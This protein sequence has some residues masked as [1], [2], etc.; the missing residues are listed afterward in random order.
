MATPRGSGAAPPPA[1][2]PPAVERILAATRPRLGAGV[3]AVALRDLG[4]LGTELDRYVG[5]RRERIER[6]RGIIEE[7]AREA[8][9]R[10]AQEVRR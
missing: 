6:E 4:A 5:R 10:L 1:G 3:D 8:L 9:R 2:R 7:L